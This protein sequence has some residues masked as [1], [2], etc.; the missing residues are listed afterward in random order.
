[1]NLSLHWIFLASHVGRV[2]VSLCFH[3]G[4]TGK[5]CV[6]VK[7]LYNTFSP[8]EDSIYRNFLSF[9]HTFLKDIC[10]YFIEMSTTQFFFR[11]LP[12]GVATAGHLLP[13]HSI[14]NILLCH[15]NPLY[16]LLRF[17]REAPLRISSSPPAWQFHIQHHLFDIST[18]CPL[19]MSIAP[20]SCF[21]N[22]SSKLLKLSCSYDGTYF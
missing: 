19:N 11:V 8:H 13:S 17:I 1:M 15:T 20:Q 22:V 21:S 2:A 18:M 12:L 9:L 10:V 3:P 7:I 14:P 5:C 6:D 4:S 16:V